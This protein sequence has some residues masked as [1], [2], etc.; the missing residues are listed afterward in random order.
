MF[1]RYHAQSPTFARIPSWRYYTFNF[2]TI[3][4]E[5]LNQP[6]IMIQAAGS[7]STSMYHRK[8]EGL[9]KVSTGG[10]FS[11][12]QLYNHVPIPTASFSFRALFANLARTTRCNF[13][14]VCSLDCLVSRLTLLCTALFISHLL[15]T[16]QEAYR[17]VIQPTPISSFDHVTTQLSQSPLPSNY[18]RTSHRLVLSLPFN[19][20]SPCLVILCFNYLQFKSFPWCWLTVCCPSALSRVQLQVS[21]LLML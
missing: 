8:R 13:G 18:S 12:Q 2:F 3:R 11:W 17:F 5:A 1:N 15:S 14:M 21:V 16:N 6:A 20:S 7:T 4:P 19:L 10:K 9:L